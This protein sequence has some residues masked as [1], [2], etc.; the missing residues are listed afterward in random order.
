MTNT[1]TPAPGNS[2]NMNGCRIRRL[3]DA[4]DPYDSV[5]KH[6]VD[7]IACAMGSYQPLLTHE[8]DLYLKSI[9]TPNGNIGSLTSESMTAQQINTST[10]AVNFLGVEEA[11]GAP[12]ISTQKLQLTSDDESKYAIRCDSQGIHFVRYLQNGEAVSAFSINLPS[13]CSPLASLTFDTTED[14]LIGTV[15]NPK[16]IVIK[17]DGSVVNSCCPVVVQKTNDA[18]LPLLEYIQT[19]DFNLATLTDRVC[20]LEKH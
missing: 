3:G 5:N 2:L 20:A 1:F 18:T 7:G 17:S 4:I 16:A 10:L 6:Y 11:L 13:P 9:N 15:N 8:T 14:V 12:Q 19:V